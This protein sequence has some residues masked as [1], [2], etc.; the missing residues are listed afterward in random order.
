MISPSTVFRSYHINNQLNPTKKQ[1]FPPSNS[2]QINQS[3]TPAL[4]RHPP[5][6]HP[7]HRRLLIHRRPAHLIK[8]QYGLILLPLI[9]RYVFPPPKQLT[10]EW[11]D[12]CRWVD[13]AE[14]GLLDGHWRLAQ[15][16]VVEGFYFLEGDVREVVLYVLDER[17]VELVG[18]F[19]HAVEGGVEV[20]ELVDLL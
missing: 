15:H 9:L 10:V 3:I 16:H 19:H 1:S 2:P 12:D 17:E 6:P 11:P 4:H 18:L 5:R 13:V 14:L 7:P 20:L 8:E